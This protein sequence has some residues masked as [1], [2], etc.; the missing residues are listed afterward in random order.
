MT[1]PKIAATIIMIIIET[2]ISGRVI[3]PSERTRRRSLATGGRLV[4]RLRPDLAE[5]DVEVE[6]AELGPGIPRGVGDDPFDR[7]GRLRGRLCPCTRAL[8]SGRVGDPR[9]TGREGR[10]DV[11][12]DRLTVRWGCVVG[13]V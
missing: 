10:D 4:V 8:T 5:V 13:D 2:S 3:P 6:V 1:A 9:P 12:G 11:D 7:R